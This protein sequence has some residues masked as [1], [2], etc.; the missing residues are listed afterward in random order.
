MESNN[1]FVH[2]HRPVSK[3][4]EKPSGE[5]FY[6][7]SDVFELDHTTLYM[8]LFLDPAFEH[9]LPNTIKQYFNKDKHTKLVLDLTMEAPNMWPLQVSMGSTFLED[10]KSQNQKKIVVKD[11]FRTF[12]DLIEQAGIDPAI[13]HFQN[14]NM[15][16]ES[17]YQEW[18]AKNSIATP[19]NVT[20]ADY[21]AFDTAETN[22]NL[23][24]QLQSRLNDQVRP[25][26]FTALNN[27]ARWHRVELLKDL[28]HNRLLDKGICSFVFDQK[29]VEQ[30]RRTDP[31]VADLLPMALENTTD[32]FTKQTDSVDYLNMP[33]LDLDQYFYALGNSYYDVITE[34]IINKCYDDQ[35]FSSF[36]SDAFWRNMY[37]TEKTWRAIFYK[38]PFLLMGNCGQLQVLKDQGFRT[39]DFLFDESYDTISD[40]KSRV[41]AVIAENLRIVTTHSLEQLHQVC[42][43]AQMKD[44]LDHNFNQMQEF[45]R[46]YSYNFKPR[47]TIP[48]SEVTWPDSPYFTGFN[49]Y[50]NVDTPPAHSIITKHQHGD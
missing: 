48:L 31:T 20:F 32:H 9:T 42:N 25:F 17:L 18:C 14:A 37:F 7:R 2:N 46:K 3:C 44:V 6:W 24:P 8:L 21:W 30:I 38:R 34:T 29:S 5:I 41:G 16:V 4:F 12:H 28:H 50:K 19:I 26:Y 35:V 10:A 47:V 43:S 39:F 40:T 23:L 22:Q 27:K 36:F 13:V 11:I 1:F 33:V 15:C 45:I 49:P